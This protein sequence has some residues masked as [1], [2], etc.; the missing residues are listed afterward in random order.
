MIS[1]FLVATTHASTFYLSDIGPR[2]MSR[3]GAYVAGANT[4]SSQWYNPA[5][6]TRVKGGMF[7]IDTA[8][9]HQF[10][11]FDRRDYPGEGP[12]DDNDNPTDLINNPVSN[13]AKPVIIPHMGFAYGWDKF[14]AFVGFTTP[15]A[16]DF[17]YPSDGPQR[18]SL[19]DTVVIHTFTGPSFAYQAL[20]WLSIGGG[21]SWNTMKIGQS[22]KIALYMDSDADVERAQSRETTDFDVLF[23]VEAQDQSAIAYNVATLI[24]P[25]HKKWA[26]GLMFQPSIAFD[27]TG[28][29]KADFSENTYSGLFVETNI[30]DNDITLDVTMPSIIRT[31]VLYRPMPNLE[32]ECSYVWE[33]WSSI[34]EL[35]V[36]N[37][38]MELETLAGVS[39]LEGPIILPTGYGNSHSIRVG[40]EL[41]QK[42]YSLRTGVLYETPG[43]PQNNL[44]VSLVDT[45]KI[46]LGLGGS[47]HSSSGLSLDIGLF[48]AFLPTVESEDSLGKRIAATVNVA[49][50]EAE[51]LEDR[52]VADGVYNSTT[53]LGAVG[54]TYRFG[55]K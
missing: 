23:E 26:I 45:E 3:G 43:V 41:T 54:L 34:K 12:L 6:L 51:I 33:G 52:I 53:I 5:T 14:T 39:T 4:I 18:Y 20:P 17:A 55:Q 8:V 2:G 47:W 15:Y 32:I 35:V 44:S 36:D 28:F 38:N 40:T 7:G 16:G 19:I 30:I 13:A 49:E 9:V 50:Q 29:M 46:G 24:E 1:L 11:D 25:E 21:V 22:R 27:A 48:T 10:I 42:S 31:G 37:V